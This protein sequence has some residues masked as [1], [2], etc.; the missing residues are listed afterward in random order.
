MTDKYWMI[1]HNADTTETG[2]P[3]NRTY[4]KTIW[5]GFPAHQSCE[6]DILSDFCFS[7]FGE[8][9]AYVQGVA[10]ATNWEIYPSSA[11]K[12]YEAAP[13]KWGGHKTKTVRLEL[14]IGKKGQVNILSEQEV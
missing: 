6:M 12:Y 1:T 9:T 7:R 8:K 4:I 3:R 2:L 10:P 13:I 5:Q 14:G 11:E